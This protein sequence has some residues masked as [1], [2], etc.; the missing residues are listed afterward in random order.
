MMLLTLSGC[1]VAVPSERLVSVAVDENL[2]VRI[3]GVYLHETNSQTH[4][5]GKLRY[6]HR[7]SLL[8]RDHLDIVAEDK[9]GVV[10]EETTT[11]IKRE[12]AT[13][14]SRSRE[15]RATFHAELASV[16]PTGTRILVKYHGTPHDDHQLGLELFKRLDGRSVL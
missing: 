16:V 5:I 9:N 1:A 13:A 7:R 2:E 10:F 8:Q 14:H 15:L 11:R 6:L 12:E 4:V 3:Y